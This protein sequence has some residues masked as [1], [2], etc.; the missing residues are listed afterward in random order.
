MKHRVCSERVAVEPFR[1]RSGI[2][3][4][5]LS[6]NRPAQTMRRVRTHVPD[7]SHRALFSRCRR[8]TRE[9]GEVGLRARKSGLASAGHEGRSRQR[10]ARALSA[11]LGRL[12]NAR[13]GP[14]LLSLLGASGG[15]SYVRRLL[16]RPPSVD[17]PHL[18]F[19]STRSGPRAE[20]GPEMVQRPLRGKTAVA[21]TTA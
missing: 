8:K 21:R 14:R 19:Q 16:K 15:P 1:W 17:P 7:V 11:E 9:Y 10:R 5:P 20:F 13:E 4:R 18:L 6:E 2:R 12:L 3:E